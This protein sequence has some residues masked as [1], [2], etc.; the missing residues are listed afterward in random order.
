MK[1]AVTQSK[2]MSARILRLHQKCS[3]PLSELE[4]LQK[5]A[6][7]MINIRNVLKYSYVYAYYLNEVKEKEL[8]EHVQGKLEENCDRLHQLLEKN[9]DEFC[10]PAIDEAKTKIAFQKYKEELS[11][12]YAV[13]EKV[14]F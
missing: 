11:N 4:F 6:E 1:L 9:L 13:T 2:E 12:Y 8:F 5:A 3:F 7:A 14:L 10:N